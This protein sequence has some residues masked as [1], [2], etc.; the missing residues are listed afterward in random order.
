MRH[1]DDEWTAT[2]FR[3]GRKLETMTLGRNIVGVVI[4]AYGVLAARS[5]ALAGLGVGSVIEIG[6]S[7]V[8]PWGLA[9][10]AQN[11]RR[12]ALRKFGLAFVALSACLTVLSTVVLVIGFRP[13]PRLVDIVGTAVTAFVMFVLAAGKLSTRRALK[14]PV[15][16]IEGRITRGDGIFALA[17]NCGLAMNP[18][19]GR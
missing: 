6:A 3:T 18:L 4:L 15:P 17:V 5:V 2:L 11:R 1:T 16:I 13:Y 7:T 12:R 19:A 8:V 10:V 14:N 9:D